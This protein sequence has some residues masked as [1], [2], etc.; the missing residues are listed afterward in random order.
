[1]WNSIESIVDCPD[2]KDNKNT[3][4]LWILKRIRKKQRATRSLFGYGG[5][6]KPKVA[7]PVIAQ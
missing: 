5:P 1:V 7:E 3:A 4:A 6:N 2:C